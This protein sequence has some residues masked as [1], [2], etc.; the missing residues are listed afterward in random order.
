MSQKQD[1]HE[2]VICYG[3]KKLGKSQANYAPTKGEMA[4]VLIFI[5]YWKYYLQFR[6][7]KLRK[8]HQSLQWLRSMNNPRGMESRWI[9]I[10]STFEFDVQYRPG[11]K[12]GN[13][14]AL[15]RIEH[16][17]PLEGEEE[18]EKDEW[19]SVN[20]INFMNRAEEMK[21][22]KPTNEWVQLQDE[23][24]TLKRIKG[25]VAN[26]DWP[27]SRERR[28]ESIACQ[29]YI[30][31]KE[32]LTMGEEN[33]LLME[34][35]EGNKLICIPLEHQSSVVQYIHQM[36][37]HKGID[38]TNET[39]T[40]LVYFPSR[41]KAVIEAINTCL[42]CQQKAGSPSTQRHTLMTVPNGYPGQRWSVDFVG[43]LPRSKKGNQFILTIKDAYTRWIEAFPL[44][45]ATAVKVIE[46]LE[47][48]VFSRFGIP[49]SLHSDRGS[50]FTGLLL[51]EVAK[52]LDISA[53]TTPAYNPKSN[54]VER[55][56]RDLKSALRAIT[57]NGEKDWESMLPYALFALR[58]GV[59]RMTG[60]SPFKLLFGRDP[61]SP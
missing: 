61:R 59:N 26:D 5:Q 40:K 45:S 18:E 36:L 39:L 22:P 24:D 15:S 19:L 38:A 33:E 7:F 28:K 10:L 51:Q 37:A 32:G 25:W 56:H 34:G 2:R 29:H 30:D 49:E 55:S 52:T 8:D 3:S 60:V 11:P 23:D 54:P 31:R 9:Y 48:E 17:E 12:H 21:M 13:A 57:D 35:G 53:T 20:F 16:A 50:Q 47:K 4:A 14:D 46:I 6:K 43:P 41:K 44:R 42:T 58:V 1:G 27:D